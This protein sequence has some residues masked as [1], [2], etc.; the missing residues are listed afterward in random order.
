MIKVNGTEITKVLVNGKE[1][2]VVKANGVIVFKKDAVDI[3]ND[4]SREALFRFDGNLDEAENRIQKESGTN[5]L[6]E[7]INGKKYVYTT[8]SQSA[9]YFQ[10]NSHNLAISKPNV[11][12]AFTLETVGY[13]NGNVF[14]TRDRGTLGTSTIPAKRS[15]YKNDSDAQFREARRKFAAPLIGNFADYSKTAPTFYGVSYDPTTKIATLYSKVK[16]AGTHKVLMQF[17]GDQPLQVVADWAA[18]YGNTRVRMLSL[19]NRKITQ[20]EFEQLADEAFNP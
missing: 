12:Y 13:G 6:Y 18:L 7:V 2:D 9:P 4:G 19:F 20:A 15:F 10:F 8:N 11:E 1:M 17:T 14:V 16:G 5:D 3:F